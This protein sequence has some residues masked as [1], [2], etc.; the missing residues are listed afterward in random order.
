MANKRKWTITRGYT[1]NLGNYESARI[2]VRLEGE[3]GESPE[4]L[5][6]AVAAVVAAEIAEIEPA[7]DA[8]SAFQNF[9]AN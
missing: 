2:E 8:R 5:G 9:T 6:K 4:E 1:A 7:L 3:E